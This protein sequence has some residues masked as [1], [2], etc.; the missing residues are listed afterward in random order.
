MSDEKKVFGR[1]EEFLTLFNQGAEYLSAGTNLLICPEGMSQPA[2]L[3]PA[4]F[5]TGAF[6]LAIDTGAKIVPIALAGFHRR[7]KDGPLVGIVGDAIDVSAM[8]EN[9]GWKTV[10]EFADGFREEFARD[11]ARAAAIA[12]EPGQF[13][14]TLSSN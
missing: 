13:S 10:R 7:F 5:H 3:S 9:Q 11:V 6:R 1:A 12:A 14:A 8:M 4:R 2:H